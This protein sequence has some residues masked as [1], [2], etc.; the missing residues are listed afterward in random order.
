MRSPPIF[1]TLERMARLVRRLAEPSR[2]AGHRRPCARIC[3]SSSGADVTR[4]IVHRR[5]RQQHRPRR[6]STRATKLESSCKIP[7]AHRLHSP[8]APNPVRLPH[9]RAESCAR[10]SSWNGVSRRELA[11]LEFSAQLSSTRLAGAPGHA[12]KRAPRAVTR[13]QPTGGTKSEQGKRALGILSS[14]GASTRAT[15]LPDEKSIPMSSG[16]R[17]SESGVPAAAEVVEIVQKAAG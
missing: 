1:A 7:F 13:I 2:C 17:T 12:A 3:K 5:Q 6:D 14:L 10:S 9:A 8:A 15:P 16:V 4:C 11:C